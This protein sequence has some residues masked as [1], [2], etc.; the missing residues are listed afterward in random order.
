MDISGKKK[1][2]ILNA[3]QVIKIKNSDV[4]DIDIRKLN[5]TGENFLTESG[6]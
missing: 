6:V 5:N 4:K 1:S 3:K 2:Y